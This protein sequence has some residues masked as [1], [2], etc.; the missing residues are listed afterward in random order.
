MF[1]P[2]D[3]DLKILKSWK[4]PGNTKLLNAK[5]TFLRCGMCLKYL[6]RMEY[7]EQTIWKSDSL[8]SEVEHPP[9]QGKTEAIKRRNQD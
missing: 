3:V 8:S 4:N 9:T 5:F 1:V 2:F 6:I 7:S